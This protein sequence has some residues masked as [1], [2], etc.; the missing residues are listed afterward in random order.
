VQKLIQAFTVLT[1]LC[2]FLTGCEGNPASSDSSSPTTSPSLLTNTYSVPESDYDAILGLATEGYKSLSLKDFNTAVKA[3]IDK[4]AGFLSTFSDLM[5]NLNPGDSEYRFVYETLNHSISEIIFPQ[6]GED[7]SLSEYLKKTGGAYNGNDGETYFMFTALYSVQYR[8]IDEANL[9]V[10]ERDKLLSAY[11]TGFQDAINDME[12]EQLMAG[13]IRFLLQKT[14]DDLATELSINTLIFENAE[15][16]SI[17]IHY[18]GQ[19]YQK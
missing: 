11:H 1:V 8:V 12:R 5:D 10:G 17:E 6:I 4:D 9:S 2:V 7:I 16:S 13:D 18:G 3:E 14:A 15:I 19:E